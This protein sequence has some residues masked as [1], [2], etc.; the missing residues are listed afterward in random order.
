MEKVEELASIFFFI[1]ANLKKKHT[2]SSLFYTIRKY[3]NTLGDSI[4]K[5]KAFAIRTW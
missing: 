4:R 1:H 3:I 2:I 5:M